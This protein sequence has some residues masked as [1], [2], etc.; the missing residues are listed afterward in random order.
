VTNSSSTAVN[1]AMY[2]LTYAFYSAVSGVPNFTCAEERSRSVGTGCIVSAVV[3]II[4]GTLIKIC[5]KN[6][7]CVTSAEI[8]TVNTL[9]H[10]NP[11]KLLMD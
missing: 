9:M 3:V 8:E 10:K 5:S 2:N 11:L 1:V 6:K 4:T 7:E